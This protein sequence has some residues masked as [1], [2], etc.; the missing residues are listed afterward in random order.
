MKKNKI[1]VTSFWDNT[2]KHSEL[3]SYMLERC[4]PDQGQSH[5]IHGEFLR[6]LARIN[7]DIFNN[8][9]CNADSM[10]SFCAFVVSHFNDMNCHFNSNEDDIEAFKKLLAFDEENDDVPYHDKEIVEALDRTI[11]K[12]IFWCE[13]EELKKSFNGDIEETPLILMNGYSKV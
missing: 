13:Y 10:N 6:S 9:F 2:N 8:G 11:E 5:T 12:A 3:F 4:V 1:Y 7:Y